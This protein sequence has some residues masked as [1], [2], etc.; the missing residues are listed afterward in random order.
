MKNHLITFSLLFFPQILFAQVR[1]I[2]TLLRDL[3][4]LIW[5]VQG[6]VTLLFFVAFI[7]FIWNMMVFVLNSGND[8]KRAAGKQRMIWGIIVLVVMFGI[9]GIVSVLQGL[10]R[11]NM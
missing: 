2:Q 4:N 7:F 6:I 5:G 11:V 1:D 3:G 10:V 9:W 8:E